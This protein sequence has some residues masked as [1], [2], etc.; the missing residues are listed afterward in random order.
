LTGKNYQLINHA[1]NTGLT[2][3]HFYVSRK[4]GIFQKIK[5]YSKIISTEAKNLFRRQAKNIGLCFDEK[6]NLLFSLVD[7]HPRE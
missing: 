5:H 4:I 3:N 7:T 1:K 2:T 6:R